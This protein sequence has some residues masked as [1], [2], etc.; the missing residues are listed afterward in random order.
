MRTQPFHI[1]DMIGQPVNRAL[2]VIVAG[3]DGHAALRGFGNNSSARAFGHGGA[4]GQI[5]WGDPESGI[6]V[7]Y[8]THGF[9]GQEAQGRRSVAI[10]SLAGACRS[11]E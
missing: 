7:G 9:V 2:A 3:D 6:S 5:G 10:S 4:G 11:G 8:C 1:N